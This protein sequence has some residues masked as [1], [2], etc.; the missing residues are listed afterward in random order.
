MT[1][2]IIQRTHYFTRERECTVH[3]SGHGRVKWEQHFGIPV[4]GRRGREDLIDSHEQSPGVLQSNGISSQ[5]PTS[6]EVI[7]K[8]V[9]IVPSSPYTAAQQETQD[10]ECSQERCPHFLEGCK[11][12]EPYATHIL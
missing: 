1:K 5:T 12:N 6:Q 4:G 3:A 10:A 7:L 11:A 2:I 8:E 9:Y